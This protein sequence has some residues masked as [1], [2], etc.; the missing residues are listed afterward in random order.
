MLSHKIIALLAAST[1]LALFVNTSARADPIVKEQ[2]EQIGKLRWL[3]TSTPTRR[4]ELTSKP[5]TKQ[6]QNQLDNSMSTDV[7][8]NRP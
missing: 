6:E 3:P 2:Q 8:A 5:I 4:K 1:A 7:P